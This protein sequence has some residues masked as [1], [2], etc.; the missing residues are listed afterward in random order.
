MFTERKYQKKRQGTSTCDFYSSSSFLRCRSDQG[1]DLEQ[2]VSQ[3]H[4]MVTTGECPLVYASLP[5]LGMMM[6]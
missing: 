5:Q 1:E 4:L 2:R 3:W 6:L